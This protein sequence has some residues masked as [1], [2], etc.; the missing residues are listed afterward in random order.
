MLVVFIK[1]LG[2]KK[3]KMRETNREGRS[4]WLSQQAG[5]EGGVHE[6]REKC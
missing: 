2:N 4:G 6:K 5:G 3:G 1:I